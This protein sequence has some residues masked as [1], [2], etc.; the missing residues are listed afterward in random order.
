MTH[1]DE[2]SNG[3]RKIP[4]RTEFERSIWNSYYSDFEK[5]YKSRLITNTS[6]PYAKIPFCVWPEWTEKGLFMRLYAAYEHPEMKLLMR[7]KMKD[8]I[9]R[10]PGCEMKVTMESGLPYCID[11][12]LHEAPVTDFVESPARAKFNYASEIREQQLSLMHYV[13]EIFHEYVA[14]S[15][16]K[17]RLS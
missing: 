7:D 8:L 6:F 2:E 17:T 1:K 11:I 12:Q 15:E 5:A 3:Q 14:E 10:Y 9:R 16:Q 13:E 4:S